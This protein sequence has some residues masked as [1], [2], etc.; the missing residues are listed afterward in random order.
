MCGNNNRAV[1]ASFLYSEDL[2]TNQKDEVSF[3]SI[4]GASF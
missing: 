4:F 1:V 3:F 2:N